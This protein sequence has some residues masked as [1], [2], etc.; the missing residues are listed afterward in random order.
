MISRGFETVEFEARTAKAQA[1]LAR[2]DLAGLLLTSEPDIRYFTGFQT[3]F[4]QSPTRPWFLFV[5]QTGKPIAVIPE[6]GEALM[7]Q[8]WIDDIRCWNAP[9]PDDDGLSILYDLLSPL[10]AKGE[11]I[12]LLKELIKLEKV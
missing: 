9:T 6:I 5:P 7:S 4:W 12:G 11:K 1:K 2:Q 10:E 3:L 8:S